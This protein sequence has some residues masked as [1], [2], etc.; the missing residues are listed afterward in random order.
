MGRHALVPVAEDSAA[1]AVNGLRAGRLP[2]QD[3]LPR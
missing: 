1:L 3:K 2:S